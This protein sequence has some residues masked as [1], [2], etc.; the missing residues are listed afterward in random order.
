MAQASTVTSPFRRLVESLPYGKRLPAAVYVHR[1]GGALGES[2]LGQ[3]T[4]QVAETHSVGDEFNVVKFRT[5]LPRLSFLSYPDFF[6]EAHPALHAAVAIDL[7]SGKSYAT[8]Y[9]DSL[10]PPILHRKELLLPPDHPSVGAFTALSA[11]EDAAGLYRD[12]AVIG[13][14]ENW[15]RLL[16]QH[17]VVIE[18]HAIRHVAPGAGSMAGDSVG[19]TVQRHRTALTRYALSRPVKTLFEHGQISSNSTF[20]DYGCGLGADVRGLRELGFTANGWDPV[21]RPS[22]ERRA[23]DVVNLGYVLNVIEDSAERISTLLSAWQLARRLLVVSVMVK[24]TPEGAATESFQD[25]VLTSRGTFQRYFGQL[26]MQQFLEDALE[27]VAVPVSLGIFYVFRDPLDHQAFLTARSRRQVDWGALNLGLGA[28]EPRI[29]RPRVPRVDRYEQHRELAEEFWRHCLDLGRL[30]TAAEFGRLADVSEAFG[31]PK[32]A[33]AA[34]LRRGHQAAFDAARAL[35]RND[36][37]VYLA[38]GNLQRKVSFS[39]LPESLRED[40][41]EHFGN[42]TRGLDA[43]MQL[44]RSA[45]DP[46]TISLACGEAQVGWQDA[47]ALYVHSPLRDQLPPVL[48]VYV[49]CAER[50]Y[51]DAGQA[52]LVKIHKMSGKVTFL[53]YES[54]ESCLLPE[55][56]LRTKVNLRTLWVE[57]FDHS[58]Q[59]EL[60][61]YK[62]RFLAADH[63]E[64]EALLSLRDSVTRLGATDSDFLGPRLAQ[65]VPALT[66]QQAEVR[67]IVGALSDAV[68]QR[69]P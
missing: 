53:T 13:F 38:V 12:T 67:A 15:N 36:L 55:L 19:V 64:R 10:N 11:A 50:L 41:R 32:R 47:D 48:R 24:G 42:Y 54:F 5:D 6:T 4:R 20:F 57:V 61:Y 23:A 16:L 9:R 52:D 17:G 35:R 37:L 62:E 28:P 45:A 29:A 18:G 8:D 33:L 22:D 26:E 14:R 25:G 40:V 51:G 31:S 30:P 44:L 65:I 68:R 58:G 46:N 2:P 39:Q 27:Q 1:E 66:G 43:G 56:S 60:L 59:G 34:I 3:L 49:A 63:P 21:H 69:L 7:S